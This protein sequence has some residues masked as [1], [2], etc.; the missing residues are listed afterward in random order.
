MTLEVRNTNLDLIGQK[1]PDDA[2]KPDKFDPKKQT[3]I[4]KLEIKQSGKDVTAECV[5]TAVSTKKWWGGAKSEKEIAFEG[6]KNLKTVL[7]KCKDSEG[8]IHPDLLKKINEFNDNCGWFQ[9]KIDTSLENTVKTKAAVEEAESGVD[10]SVPKLVQL[11]KDNQLKGVPKQL[12]DRVLKQLIDKDS[13]ALTEVGKKVAEKCSSTVLK[14]FK[15]DHSELFQKTNASTSVPEAPPM[16]PPTP[17]PR[18]KPPPLPHT[19]VQTGP[20]SSGT[21]TQPAP[22]A[23]PK[24]AASPDQGARVR[25]E[26]K[27]ADIAKVKEIV[28]QGDY[29]G[30][31]QFMRSD[32]PLGNI[33]G[34]LKGQLLLLACQAEDKDRQLGL[35][36][37][38]INAC[39]PNELTER[40]SVYNFTPLHWACWNGD[41]ETASAL[42]GRLGDRELG[43]KGEVEK[44]KADTAVTPLGV[45]ILRGNTDLV[46]KIHEKYKMITPKEV[47][48]ALAEL[49]KY[50]R[51]EPAEPTLP[52]KM[53]DQL[54]NLKI[55]KA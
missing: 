47:K 41:V 42:I 31:K 34:E 43:L 5:A 7:T 6:L 39:R 36:L 35:S 53:R 49:E 50:A 44:G 26:R 29:E 1:A 46:K 14:Q 30:L 4:Y 16:E 24:I 9:R 28:A 37:Q 18:R 20:A 11:I 13:E 19:V 32:K 21:T 22:V 8:T 27:A 3:M 25:E 45:A 2:P 33:S 23:L 48:Y 52:E 10:E 54:A 17:T 55:F 40:D 12:N 15:K 38:I 51:A